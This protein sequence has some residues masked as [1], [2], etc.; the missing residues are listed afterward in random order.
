MGIYNDIQEDLK[1]AMA[2]DLAD[3]VA[4]L[5]ITET[6]SSTSY[7][8]ANGTVSDV[9]VVSTMRCI[10]VD[11][12]VQDEQEAYSETTKNMIE[13]MVLDSEKTCEFKTGLMAS[14]RG[15]DYEV[16]KYNV[17]PVGATHSLYLR[18]L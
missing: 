8:P 12:D 10:V 11:S 16:S 13:V 18:G 6:S 1:E 17:D 3:A 4:S 5:V 2:D 7:N 9:P 15:S 14:V